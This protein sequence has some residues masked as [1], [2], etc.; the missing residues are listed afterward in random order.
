MAIPCSASVTF[1]IR[2]NG[3]VRRR[4]L[5]AVEEWT[6]EVAQIVAD[7]QLLAFPAEMIAVSYG[8]KPSADVFSAA[9]LVSSWLGIQADYRG[10]AAQRAE[11]DAAIVRLDTQPGRDQRRGAE[12]VGRRLRSLA[13]RASR[14][15]A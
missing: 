11:G 15:A 2:G 10:I 4:H 13:T 5:H 14:W 8:A 7:V 1:M 9:A 12:D 6:R 3:D